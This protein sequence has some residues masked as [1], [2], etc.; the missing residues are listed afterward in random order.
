[1]S[2][3]ITVLQARNCSRVY[4]LWLI[5]LEVVDLIWGH[6]QKEMF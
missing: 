1:M 5:Y 3:I 4:L 6:T 2:F